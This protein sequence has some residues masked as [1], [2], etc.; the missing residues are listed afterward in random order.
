MR[1]GLLRLSGLAAL[2]AGC[3]ASLPP[4]PARPSPAVAEATKGRPSPEQVLAWANLD[5]NLGR[6]PERLDFG[7]ADGR[8]VLSDKVL[9]LNGEDMVRF[10]RKHGYAGH[11]GITTTLHTESKTTIHVVVVGKDGARMVLQLESDGDPQGQG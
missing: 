9:V 5:E 4:E 2:L 1:R 8:S 6:R 11:R 3:A 10:V 7:Q